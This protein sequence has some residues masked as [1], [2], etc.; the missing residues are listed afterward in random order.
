MIAANRVGERRLQELVA[1]YGLV[2]TERYGQALLDYGQR[3]MQEVLEA[4]PDGCYLFS[5]QL[6]DD[7]VGAKLS[8]PFGS[9]DH[10]G[11]DSVL[12]AAEGIKEL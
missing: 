4:I 11:S 9:V 3:L 2:E 1:R 12:D 6:D 5:D 8:R 7:G 10:V